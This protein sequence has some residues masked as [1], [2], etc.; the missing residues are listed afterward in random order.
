MP[1]S[2]AAEN[3]R[4]YFESSSVEGHRNGLDS[5]PVFKLS[6]IEQQNDRLIIRQ[7]DEIAGLEFSSEFV[8]DKTTSV[9]KHVI[10]YV[11]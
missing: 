7:T 1:V 4:G 10:N 6:K 2:L 11:I 8:L 9:L 5:M 3:G